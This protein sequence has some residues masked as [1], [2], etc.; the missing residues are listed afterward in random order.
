MSVKK[1]GFATL[2]H[3]QLRAVSRRGGSAKVPKG[4][5]TLSEE[6]RKINARKGALA[7]HKKR[8]ERRQHGTNPISKRD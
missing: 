8:K 7:M 6:E 3:E 1:Q 4:F 5:A 2:S